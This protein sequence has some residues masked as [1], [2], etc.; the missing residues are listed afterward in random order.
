MLP[1]T[2]VAAARPPGRRPGSEPAGR[3]SFL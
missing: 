1:A 3:R 2:N